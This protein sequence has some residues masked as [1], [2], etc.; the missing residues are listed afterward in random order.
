MEA[1]AGDGV[2]LPA[3]KRIVVKEDTADLINITLPAR[4]SELS[5]DALDSVAGEYRYPTLRPAHHDEAGAREIGQM[6]TTD[7]RLEDHPSPVGGDLAEGLQ[8]C[9]ER[10]ERAGRAQSP[11]L[12]L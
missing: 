2:E 8:L 5:G 12:V 3:G 1:F 9:R 11:S 6:S 10:V 7:E 4:Q